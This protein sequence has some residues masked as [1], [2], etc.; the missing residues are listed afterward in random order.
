MIP[1][2]QVLERNGWHPREMLISRKDTSGS[3]DLTRKQQCKPRK[4]GFS[5]HGT[6]YALRTWYGM[7][8]RM[9]CDQKSNTPCHIHLGILAPPFWLLVDYIFI[10]SLQEPRSQEDEK[11]QSNHPAHSVTHI[12]RSTWFLLL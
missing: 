7:E 2:I 12:F 8:R 6:G 11:L 10:Y 4:L 3:S 1:K 5:G 9:I